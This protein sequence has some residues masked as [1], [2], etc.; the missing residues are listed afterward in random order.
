[1]NHQDRRLYAMCYFHGTLESARLAVRA[2]ALLWNFH[3]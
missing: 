1:M 3:P 2:M